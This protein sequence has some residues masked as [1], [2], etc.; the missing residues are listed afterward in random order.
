[1]KLFAKHTAAL[2]LLCCTLTSVQAE[3]IELENP[4]GVVGKVTKLH[5]TLV[6]WPRIT[7]DHQIQISNF[8]ERN[9]SMPQTLIERLELLKK[10]FECINALIDPPTKK[11]AVYSVRYP[12]H[13]PFIDL[14][15]LK[16]F[17]TSVITVVLHPNAM[18][19]QLNYI[20]EQT[21]LR[22][23]SLAEASLKLKDYG[24][25]LLQAPLT[26]TPLSSYSPPP[27]RLET[28]ERRITGRAPHDSDNRFS[29]DFWKSS[30]E[31]SYDPYYDPSDRYAYIQSCFKERPS[32]P[33]PYE[34]PLVIRDTPSSTPTASTTPKL[35][36]QN[37]EFI[38]LQ[39]QIQLDPAVSALRKN[40]LQQLASNSKIS[41]ANRHQC[42][43]A[44]YEA[45]LT[46][47]VARIT[48][49]RQPPSAA[50]KPTFTGS[51]KEIDTNPSHIPAGFENAPVDMR[52]RHVD[53]TA[54]S[55][56][57]KAT[58]TTEDFNNLARAAREIWD[59]K[60][61]TQQDKDEAL[62][63]IKNKDISMTDKIP[64]L[65]IIRDKIYRRQVDRL[66]E[67]I[68]RQQI[69]TDDENMSLAVLATSDTIPYATKI[70][71]LQTILKQAKDRR[72]EWNKKQ[73]LYPIDPP[74]YEDIPVA[75]VVDTDKDA[76]IAPVVKDEKK[77]P[78]A[79]E[80]P[81]YA[82]YNARYT[83][84]DGFAPYDPFA[85][86]DSDDDSAPEA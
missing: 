36:L 8:V 30:L 78:S 15:T 2:F 38:K 50:P 73:A 39:Q 65:N 84:M 35:S 1:M 56:K 29:D 71:S 53:P 81:R 37:P 45:I 24:R 80:D 67:E 22:A 76:P 44:I 64:I 31:R 42:V 23:T 72:T 62:S 83:S 70:E 27:G 43:K 48:Y 79:K 32:Y 61:W 40:E 4:L 58:P 47:P 46:D 34:G 13:S 10:T 9:A 33:Q 75:E 52:L 54:T 60:A 57:V 18:P 66:C 5:K 11:P 21:F 74:T 17:F 85:D 82:G 41:E 7:P 3:A 55:S 51:G 86:P 28:E 19:D 12:T 25:L 68:A 16:R 6:N 14:D 77:G 26:A 69:L 59:A 20:I 63:V 49:E